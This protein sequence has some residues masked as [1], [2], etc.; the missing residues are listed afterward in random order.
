MSLKELYALCVALMCDDH[1]TTPQMGVA[2]RNCLVELADRK[3]KENGFENWTDFYLKLD[4]PF[5]EF[6]MNAAVRS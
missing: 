2:A 4:M 1:V 5:T 6:E 3:A